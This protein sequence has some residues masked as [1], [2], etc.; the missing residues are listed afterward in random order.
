MAS[1]KLV[2]KRSVTR[3]LRAIPKRDLKRIL[4]KIESLA[5]NPRPPGSEK[6]SSQERYRVRQGKYR[7]IYEIQNQQLV[8]VVVKV[9]HRK[10][11]YR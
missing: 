11:V 3:D 5:E 6:L 2:F 8:I 9:A 7:I 4:K 10:A 1:Y